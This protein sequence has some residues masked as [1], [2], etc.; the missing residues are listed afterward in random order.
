MSTMRLPLILLTFSLSACAAK[1]EEATPSG[2]KPAP[3]AKAAAGSD[4]LRDLYVKAGQRELK[5]LTEQ[6][7]AGTANKF[8][9][10]AATASLD[11]IEPYD[12]DTVVEIRRLCDHDIPL[13]ILAKGVPTAEAARGAKPDAITL[14]ACTIDLMMAVEAI[15]AANAHDDASRA[16]VER[17]DKACPLQAKTRAD[18][19]QRTAQVKR[20]S[21]VVP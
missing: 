6:L 17:L 19:A 14:S 4:Q 11:K 7:A 12:K 5:Q 16:L 15:D 13:A 21:V 9:C 20:P 8:A 10:A 18:R 3:A 1:R 2:D